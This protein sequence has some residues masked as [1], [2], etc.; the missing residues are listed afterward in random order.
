MDI[1][2]R[3]VAKFPK[4]LIKESTDKKTIGGFDAVGCIKQLHKVASEVRRL[5]EL[6]RVLFDV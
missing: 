2:D 1:T 3:A 5:Q 4:T 6:L